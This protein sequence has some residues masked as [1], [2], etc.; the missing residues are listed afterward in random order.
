METT[1]GMQRTKGSWIVCLA[2]GCPLAGQE[3][4]AGV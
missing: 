4:G 2:G 1:G 3:R